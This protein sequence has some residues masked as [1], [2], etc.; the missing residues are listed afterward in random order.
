MNSLLKTKVQEWLSSRSKWKS[1]RGSSNSHVRCKELM[2]TMK[3]ARKIATMILMTSFMV[4][5]R[6]RKTSLAKI[7]MTLV[8]M[9]TTIIMVIQ[10]SAIKVVIQT[11]SNT[12]SSTNRKIII[13]SIS[14]TINS[15]TTSNT[16]S[17]TNSNVASTAITNRRS[18]ANSTLVWQT[19]WLIST[20][21]KT[22]MS[23]RT[24]TLL[25]YKYWTSRKWLA[26]RAIKKWMQMSLPSCSSQKLRALW[27]QSK[28]N[29]MKM[30]R[31]ISLCMRFS[32]SNPR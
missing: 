1:N 26:S 11:I 4:K 22:L 25:S 29:C 32:N 31:K 15:S 16:L 3:I 21:A 10:I 20:M 24:T 13:N 18:K 2:Q 8:L 14:L 9:S 23:T 17:R 6:A 19:C 7:L 12:S 27:E 5:R 30:Q 28:I